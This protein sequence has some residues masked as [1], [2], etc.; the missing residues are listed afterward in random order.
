MKVAYIFGAL[1]QG[2]TESLVLDVCSRHAIASYDLL[3]VYRKEG[4]LSSA[5]RKSGAE[6]ICLPVGRNI[7]KYIFQLRKCF[8]HN[9]INIIHAQTPSTAL[10]CF[11]AKV[12]LDV[13]LVTTMHGF[14]F[15]NAKPWYRNL[16]FSKSDRVVFVSQY[17]KS[18]YAEKVKMSGEDGKY[19]VVYN[20]VNFSKIDQAVPNKD[21][22]KVGGKKI[23]LMM[24]G[25]FVS[26]R[27]QIVI[28]KSIAMLKQRRI[29][30]FDFYFVGRRV[31]NEAKLYDE[32]VDY[33]SQFNLANVHFLG[34][35]DD[36]PSLLKSA[37]GF[38]YSTRHDTFGIAVIEAMAA[39][40]PVV[41]NDWD[42]MKE[43]CADGNEEWA[44]FYRS[45]DVEDCAE[46][47]A[48]L[49]QNIDIYKGKAREIALQVRQK[50][51]IEKHIDNLAKLYSEI[52]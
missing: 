14:S 13:K 20:G 45:N 31:E 3:C 24:V 51:S 21:L 4:N 29:T 18:Y 34:A 6:L 39:G 49:I 52:I 9:K 7:L 40:L 25:N 44:T 10:L 27:S 48:D 1:N 15:R 8:V 12:G 2:G 35:R 28:V 22:D 17:E 26:G 11:G 46:K 41:V 47:M 50:Y 32:C 19:Q 16:I 5:Y 37:D 36:V 43:V 30:N 38:V 33:C 23:K 42:V